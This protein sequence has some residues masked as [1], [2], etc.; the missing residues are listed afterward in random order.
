[1]KLPVASHALLRLARTFAIRLGGARV[2]NDTCTRPFA[3][4]C[5]PSNTYLLPA[6]VPSCFGT[7][8]AEADWIAEPFE[9][10]FVGLVGANR[11]ARFAHQS[12]FFCHSAS[13]ISALALP[14]AGPSCKYLQPL[15][16]G[17]FACKGLPKA[18]TPY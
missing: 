17:A 16:T 14:I 10:A 15:C 2:V 7:V 8:S 5:A 6:D 4:E 11:F 13:P 1:M 9:G 18:Y 3:F 12:F